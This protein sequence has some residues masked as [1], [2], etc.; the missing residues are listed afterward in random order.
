[1]IEPAVL[2]AISAL[3]GT[4]VASIATSWI[5]QQGLSKEQRAARDKGERQ[6]LYKA[7]IQEAC[8]LYIDAVEHNTSEIT[9]L[10]DIYAT[11]NRIRVLSSPE[12]VE[13]AH[14]ALQGILDVYS[15][16]NKTF[17]DVAHW[18][19]EGFMDPLRSFSEACHGD[20]Q[21]YS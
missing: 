12:V 21:R 2:P 10:I 6:E 7:F 15:R 14:R 3:V 19:E 13:E 4:F 20:L 5:G 8:K 1:M 11:L 18:V 17:A 9:K 16:E